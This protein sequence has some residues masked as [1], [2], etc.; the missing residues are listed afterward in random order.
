MPTFNPLI[1]LLCD[2]CVQTG[3]DLITILIMLAVCATSPPGGLDYLYNPLTHVLSVQLWVQ[4]GLRGQQQH[5]LIPWVLCV[6]SPRGSVCLR[7]VADLRE[8][9]ALWS[10]FARMCCSGAWHS[11]LLWL[12]QNYRVA[13]VIARW[14]LSNDSLGEADPLVSSPRLTRTSAAFLMWQWWAESRR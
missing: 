2:C 14:T 13:L 11:L 6:L 3:Q 9:G 1:R 12:T 4:S 7:P 8:R 10:E 5:A